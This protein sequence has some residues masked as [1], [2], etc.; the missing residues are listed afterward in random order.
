MAIFEWDDHYEIG[1]PLIDEHHQHL[2]DLLNKTYKDFINYASPDDLNVL[3]DELIDYAT[4]HFAAEEQLMQEKGYP[5]VKIHKG[6]HA[7]FARRVVEM[8]ADYQSGRKVRFL[9]I[10]SFLRNWLETHILQS[11]AALGSFLTS[12]IMSTPSAPRRT[13]ADT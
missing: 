6:E 8:Y 3:F 12:E 7:E 4:Y 5:G 13:N 10:L 9:E 1:V 2:V 11:D